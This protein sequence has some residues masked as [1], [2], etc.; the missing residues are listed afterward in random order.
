MDGFELYGN[1]IYW[2]N[3]G[4]IP[5]GEIIPA[6]TGQVAIRS[7]IA[8]SGL[9][10]SS[11]R[12][13]Y[14][15]QSLELRARYQSAARNDDWMVYFSGPN[16]SI[17][18]QKKGNYGP[19]PILNDFSGSF[20]TEAGAILMVG[21]TVYFAARGGH[22]SDNGEV[23]TKDINGPP[24]GGDVIFK[25]GMGLVK[26]MK[27]VP[28]VEENGAIFNYYVILLNTLGQVWHVRLPGLFDPTTGP[29]T[30]YAND[31]ADFDWR[32]ESEL[33]FQGGFLRRI[34]GTRLYFASSVSTGNNRPT[35]KLTSW[36]FTSGGITTEHDTFSQNR[37]VTSVTVDSARIFITETPLFESAPGDWRW[38]LP[39]SSLL[40]KN[41][42]TTRGTVFENFGVI[43]NLVEGRNLRS[44]TNWLY[45]AHQNEIRKIKTDSP[46][47]QLDYRAVGLE[48]VQ[49]VQ[50]FNNSIPL[51]A[52]KSTLVRGYAQVVVNT[53]QR[54][55]YR[56][57][58][59]LR[60]FRNGVPLPGEVD[61]YSNPINLLA[62]DLPTL[63][64]NW[65]RA[66]LFEMPL[67]WIDQAGPMQL[68]MT[69][70]PDGTVPEIGS[71]AFANNSASITVNVAPARVPCLVF[72]P[73]SSPMGNYDP[74]APGS[75]F[76][77]I[78]DRATSLLP[79]SGFKVYHS[80][81]SVRK[82]VFPFDAEAF[83]MPGDQY[84]ALAWMTLSHAFTRDPNG[85]ADTHWVGMFPPNIGNWSGLAGAR[86]VSLRD[87]VPDADINITLPRTAL[88][89]TSVV[90][91]NPGPGNSSNPWSTV[92]G[93][94][95]LAHEL[96]HNYGRFHIDQTLSG[97]GCGGSR[98]LFPYH[99]L[100]SGID[101]CTLGIIDLNNFAAPIGYDVR[102]DTLIRP[103]AAG[104]LM[105]YAN[106]SWISP[107]TWNALVGAI[108]AHIPP[109]FGAASAGMTVMLNPQPLPPGGIV[110]AQGIINPTTRNA[111]LMPS[112]QLPNGILDDDKIQESLG[113]VSLPLSMPYK[114]RLLDAGGSVLDERAIIP[115]VPSE[116]VDGQFAFVQAVPNLPGANRVQVLHGSTVLNESRASQ[117]APTLALT[118]P[119]VNVGSETLSLQW[120]ASDADNDPLLFSVQFSPDDGVSW[121]SLSVHDPALGFTVS[122]RH[123]RGGTACLLRVVATDGFRTTMATTAP[124]NVARHASSLTISGIRNQQQIPFNSNVVVRVFAYDAEDGAIESE[125]I[126]WGIIGP[127]SRSGRGG[128]FS[129]IGLAPGNYT[130]SASAPDLDGNTGLSTL[131]FT[132][133]PMEVL[134]GALPEVDGIL[135]EV[136]P[137]STEMR[138][139]PNR[140]APSARLLHAG[141]AL[142]V[143]F[144]GL[145]LPYADPESSPA[146]IN[147][148]IDGD[149]IATSAPQAN[150]VGFG[151]TEDGY[152][153][154]A[155]GT[156]AGWTAENPQGFEVKILRAA[157]SWSAEFRVPDSLL[158][159]WNHASAITVLHGRGFGSPVVWPP[160]ANVFN[161]STWSALSLG[162]LPNVTN[163]PPVAVASAPSVVEFTGT[164]TVALDGLGSY[165]LDGDPLTF[166][167]TQ[168]GG[169]SVVLANA[170][171][172]TP[173]F[174]TPA[175]TSSASLTFQLVVSDGARSST[176][177]QV[178]VL[179][180]PSKVPP[181]N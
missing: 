11:T 122:T 49:A 67:H 50:D 65:D 101:P 176:P 43:A 71:A 110:L 150:D 98:P 164:E 40:R 44:D 103:E 167:W 10:T 158:G 135:D 8:G 45:F 53:T 99:F 177:Q 148:Y 144:D 108:P 145:P 79:V 107:F 68:Q 100:P 62:G 82:P 88:D 6:R 21:P 149:G 64:P 84:W 123:L 70:N 56:M 104:D 92:G 178:T 115:L 174:Q 48:A 37:Q 39:N 111:M 126:S 28:L 80:K 31:V 46:D 162:P 117:N 87:I 141:G 33:V 27:V 175:I 76:W 180:A 26:K 96:G 125:A 91:M 29:L 116:M 113:A 172:A 36:N 171:T 159:G 160:N 4:A 25:Q 131:G 13:H 127:V 106:S 120:T 121:E 14:V 137:D 59:R 105:T 54:S 86:G 169:S 57:T 2:W 81:G 32:A 153:A 20:F 181:A 19:N 51:I 119:A 130:L 15:A 136:Y 112:F 3:D 114:L 1:G 74:S 24:G 42:P 7:L 89:N 73:M 22:A 66:F 156:G 109:G 55:K 52:G 154:R 17:R 9:V 134:D 133:R 34:H 41:S 142:Y 30:L 166:S 35:G 179:L 146:D 58:A 94:E 170:N 83:S 63:R 18:I 5:D 90:R 61:A 124:F 140:A 128:K 173:S 95:T 138:L 72:K 93:G 129:T 118:T 152:P 151:V 155:S 38:N 69:I 75:G 77:D 12:P 157:L 143:C 23:R 60:A 147:F 132:V 161:P 78:V 16:G 97:R 163:R 165:D 102:T 47:L 168:T 139:Y 85:C